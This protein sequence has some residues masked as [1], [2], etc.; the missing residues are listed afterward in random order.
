MSKFRSWLIKKLGGISKDELCH[1]PL[2]TTISNYELCE[3]QARFLPYGLTRDVPIEFIK[4]RLLEDI[5][6]R[7]DLPIETRKN[8]VLNSMEYISKIK[9]PKE[10]IRRDENDR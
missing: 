8:Q 5:V 3:I 2:K 10:Y 6:K 1:I 9:I 4:R 7:I